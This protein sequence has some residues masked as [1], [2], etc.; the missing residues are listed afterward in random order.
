MDKQLAEIRKLHAERAA[1]QKR[2]G[3]AAGAAAADT[4]EKGK[5]IGGR[6]FA[7]PPKQL[8]MKEY[9]AI[10]NRYQRVQR[11]KKSETVTKV[12]LDSDTVDMFQSF[13][14][15]RNFDIQRVGYVYG[16]V[17]EGVVKV[18]ACYEPDQHS[19]EK[20]YTIQEDKRLPKVDA[21]A[22]LLGLQR[23]GVLVSALPASPEDPVLTAKEVLLC[24]E[25]QAK[26]GLHCSLIQVRIGADH[27][28]HVEAYQVSTQCVDIYKEGTLSAHENPKFVHSERE[29][30]AVQE[31][32]SPGGE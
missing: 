2:E 12:E 25:Q 11:Q 1:K 28:I 8:G 18:H 24:A 6:Y 15:R 16:T 27:E 29:L 23:V 21:I 7:N 32:W 17:K 22:Q 3:P 9:E 14:R 31:V 5:V 10:V 26:H 13:L 19:T 30:E 4:K 20:E